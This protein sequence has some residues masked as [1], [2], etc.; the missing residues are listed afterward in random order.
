M[1]LSGTQLMMKRL[2][3]LKARGFDIETVR[4][5]RRLVNINEINNSKMKTFEIGTFTDP[6]DGKS[7]VNN[8]NYSKPLT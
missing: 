3:E 5:V 4:A 2:V 7:Y 1:T 6:R 8:V